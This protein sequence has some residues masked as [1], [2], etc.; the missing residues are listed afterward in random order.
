M[1]HVSNNS[2]SDRSATADNSL[3][4]RPLNY[5]RNHKLVSLEFAGVFAFAGMLTSLGVAAANNGPAGASNPTQFLQ[6]HLYPGS[7]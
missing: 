1:L 2:D 7:G 3:F 5:I 4:A 6:W